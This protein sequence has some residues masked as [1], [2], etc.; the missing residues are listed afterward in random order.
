MK[1]NSVI[2]KERKNVLNGL[3]KVQDYVNVTKSFFNDLD[4]VLDVSS[5][6]NDVKLLYE[7]Y[8]NSLGVK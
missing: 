3:K 5:D 2:L 4:N 6:I 8:K 7:K 1:K